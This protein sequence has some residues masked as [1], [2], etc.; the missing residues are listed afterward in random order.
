[1]KKT[2]NYEALVFSQRHRNVVYEEVVAALEHAAKKQGITRS[3]IAKKLGFTKSHISQLL[4]GPGNWTLDTVS[5]LL[6]AVDAELQCRA[7]FFADLPIANR[8]NEA[9]ET[10][11]HEHDS[12]LPRDNK[13]VTG[14]D[15]VAPFQLTLAA[16]E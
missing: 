16:A 7:V 3:D 11:Q 1:M 14:T 9:G 15:E 2:S 10:T 5:N 6:F 13:V 12:S 4:S 8:Y